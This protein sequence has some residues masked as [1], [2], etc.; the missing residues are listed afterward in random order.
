M[1][2]SLPSD[3]L[4]K[5][6]RSLRAAYLV[7]QAGYTLGIA[8]HDGSA[9]TALLPKG[10]IAEVSTA[11]DELDVASRDKVNI[12]SESK[13]STHDQDAAARLLKIWRRKVAKRAQR[14]V[15]MGNKLPAELT[16]I[17][18]TTTV[19]GL[20][21]NAKSALALLT[22]AAP[23]LDQVGPK[24][25]ALITEGEQLCD[26]LTAADA[27]QEQ[28][29]GAELPATVRAFR[30]KKGELY[31]GLKVIHDAGH[32]LHA[33]DAQAA[34]KYNLSILHRHAGTIAAAA[35]APTTDTTAPAQ[36]TVKK[37]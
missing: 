23:I 7:Q 16:H 9:L 25:K 22:A 33:H 14:A 1:I 10:Y 21:D 20:L 36:P 32:E 4:E 24:T 37:T 19:P 17:G 13:T 6:G 35:P 2:T 18:R 26:S 34:A 8:A 5:Q 31:T 12:A 11:R 27:E 3:Q 30:A 28:L 29:T 15:R